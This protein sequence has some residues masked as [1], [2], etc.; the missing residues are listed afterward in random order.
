MDQTIEARLAAMGVTLPA[1]AAPIDRASNTVDQREVS[2]AGVLRAVPRLQRDL[3]V[4][5]NAMKLRSC[6]TAARAVRGNRKCLHRRIGIDEER[7]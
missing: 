1:A 5:K 4:V 7:L 2:T 3:P 6:N